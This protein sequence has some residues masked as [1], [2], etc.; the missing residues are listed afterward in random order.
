MEIPLHNRE[1]EVVAHAVV[2]DVDAALAQHRWCLEGRSGYVIRRVNRRVVKLHREILGLV[3]GDGLFGD[4]INGDHLDNRRANLR[5]TTQPQ[6]AQNVCSHRDSTSRHR[7]VSLC[8]RTGRWVAQA[9]VGGVYRFLGRHVTEDEAARV[10]AR[11]RA[12][13]MP[14]ATSLEGR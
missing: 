11:F 10:A 4:H 3:P 13:H 9:Q 14:F 12:E 2:D 6:S 7:G 5:V 8:S 1:G